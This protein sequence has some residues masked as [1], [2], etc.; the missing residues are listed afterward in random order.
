MKLRR[1]GCQSCRVTE[2]TV[3]APE[4]TLL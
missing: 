1:V 3:R 2:C 4:V